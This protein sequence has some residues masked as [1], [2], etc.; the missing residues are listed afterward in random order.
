[1]V[2]CTF[3]NAR[4]L[5]YGGQ[6]DGPVSVEPPIVGRPENFGGAV[7]SF[8]VTMHAAPTTLQAEDP[9]TLT[10]RITGTGRLDQVER[11]DL[12]RL[13]KFAREFQIDNLSDRYLPNDQAREFDYR[14]RPRS[15]LVKQIPRLPFVYFKPGFVPDYRG[16]QTTYAPAIPLTVKPRAV[17]QASQVQGPPSATTIPESV[18]RLADGPAVLRHEDSSILPAPWILSVLLLGPPLVSL[19]WYVR[20]RLGNPDAGHL[21][22]RRRSRA[23]QEALKAL[24]SLRKTPPGDQAERAEQIVTEYLHQRF[25]FRVL[26]PTPVEAARYLD[27]QG[28]PAIQVQEVASFFAACDTARFAPGLPPL[29]ETWSAAGRHLIHFLEDEPC[30]SPAA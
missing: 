17:V 24:E 5:G 7:G 23:A 1:M 22:R 4:G 3:G 10:V 8:T 9:L 6:R 15:A 25:D 28:L 12:R 29:K 2:L 20:W 13:P 30:P 16:Y 11:P 27:G 19:L 26:A 14:L 18:L 21:A